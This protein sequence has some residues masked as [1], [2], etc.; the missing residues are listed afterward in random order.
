MNYIKSL[1]AFDTGSMKTESVF[2]HIVLESKFNYFF[3]RQIIII[4][5]VSFYKIINRL[6]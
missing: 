5:V 4:K 1:L 6:S 3:L 2:R